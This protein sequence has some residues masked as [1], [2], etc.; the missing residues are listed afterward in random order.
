ME[1]FGLGMEVPMPFSFS[2]EKL[3]TFVH[4]FISDHPMCVQISGETG[5]W[6]N[7]GK[8]MEMNVSELGVVFHRLSPCA[9]PS[10]QD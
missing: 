7:P 6:A 1:L 2:A 10:S 4:R 3:W 9:S 5:S 8:L